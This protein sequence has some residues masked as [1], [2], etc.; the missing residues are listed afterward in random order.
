[1]WEALLASSVSSK[2]VTAKIKCSIQENEIPVIIVEYILISCQGI[3]FK[4]ELHTARYMD[5]IHTQYVGLYFRPSSPEIYRVL[6][7]STT[8]S[9]RAKDK[10]FFLLHAT[11]YLHVILLFSIFGIRP[12]FIEF[13]KAFLHYISVWM[14]TQCPGRKCVH[15]GVS[16]AEI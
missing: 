15:I 10:I 9:G 7:H 14:D 12:H 2:M 4:V 3:H 5:E 1:M 6:A 11:W 8:I 13:S 16:L